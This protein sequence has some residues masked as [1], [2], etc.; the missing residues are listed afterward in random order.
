L[1]K[2]RHQTLSDYTRTTLKAFQPKPRGSSA[3]NWRKAR[4]GGT[5]A[6]ST[7]RGA[8][9]AMFSRHF[10]GLS[11]REIGKLFDKYR[12]NEC[13]EIHWNV[14]TSQSVILFDDD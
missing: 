6:D 8:M 9:I 1:D 11:A 12:L 7:D 2:D 4:D 14:Q 13:I 10:P 3:A 5:R